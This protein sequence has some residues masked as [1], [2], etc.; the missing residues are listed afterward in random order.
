VATGQNG[1]VAQATNEQ[2]VEANSDDTA[3]TDDRSA[4]A[5]SV[6]ADETEEDKLICKRVGTAVTGSKLSGKRRVCRTQEQW[7][8][9]GR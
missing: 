7:D 2:S 9:Q 4:S 6:A 5:E 8:A 1:S 3:V